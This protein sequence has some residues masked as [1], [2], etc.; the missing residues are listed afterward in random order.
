MVYIYFQRSNMGE[1]HL[2]FLNFRKNEKRDEIQ[3]VSLNQT[4]DNCSLDAITEMLSNPFEELYTLLKPS[5]EAE[6]EAYE[7]SCYSIGLS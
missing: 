4:Q 2:R 1:L 6:N 3:D 5:L 7:L